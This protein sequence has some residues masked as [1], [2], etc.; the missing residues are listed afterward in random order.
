MAQQVAAGEAEDTPLWLA[1]GAQTIAAGLQICRR[2]QTTLS[3]LYILR[4]PPKFWTSFLFFFSS[5]C[6][7]A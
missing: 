6:L 3:H 5:L 1:F 7:L 4:L 2:A